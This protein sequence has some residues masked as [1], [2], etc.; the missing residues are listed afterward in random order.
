MGKKMAANTVQQMQH[1][2]WQVTVAYWKLADVE[3][4]L[5]MRSRLSE[6][7]RVLLRYTVKTLSVKRLKRLREAQIYLLIITSAEMLSLSY[8]SGL[9]FCN[10]GLFVLSK[11]YSRDSLGSSN[12]SLET[13]WRPPGNIWSLGKSMYSPTSWWEVAGGC[14][15]S[16]DEIWESLHLC[17]FGFS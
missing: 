7:L 9:C 2:H 12:T 6:S 3:R 10:F 4:C 1:K 8:S 13:S 16:L 11:G 15:L 5:F 14:L 17:D